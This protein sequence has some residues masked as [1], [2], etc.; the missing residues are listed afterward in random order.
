MRFITFI[1]DNQRITLLSQNITDSIKK[2]LQ[3]V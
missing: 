1:A 3:K 2:V